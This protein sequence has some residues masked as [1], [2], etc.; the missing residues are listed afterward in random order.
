MRNKEAIWFCAGHGNV[1]VVR[2]EDEYGVKYYIGAC[3]GIDEQTDIE[4]IAAWGSTFPATAGKA[5][6]M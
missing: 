3:G 2:S 5:L 1:G 6:F 4:H